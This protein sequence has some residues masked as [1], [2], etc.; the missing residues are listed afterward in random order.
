M[1][2]TDAVTPSRRLP[3]IKRREQ[4]L[5][6]ATR[7][8]ARSG[9]AATG[10]D[11]V[12]ESAGISRAILYRHF[13]SKADLYRAAVEHSRQQLNDRVGPAPYSEQ[14]IDDLLTA[15]SA[16][17]NGFRLLFD[18]AG[19]EPEFRAEIDKFNADMV[20]MA[21]DHLSAVVPDP[22]WAQWAAHLAPRTT[23]AAITAWLDSGQ[24]NPEF[25][26]GRIKHLLRGLSDAADA[27]LPT[28]LP[29]H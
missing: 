9:F 18:Q 27:R 12:A 3:R 19:R 7:I 13:D 11:D 26:A 21:Y 1:T 14:I 29:S 6:A 16:D 5:I 20:T 25:A 4:I 15:A 28:Q 2:D 17:P 22:A 10:L 8:F 23:I 24:P